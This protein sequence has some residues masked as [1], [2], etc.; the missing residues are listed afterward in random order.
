MDGD[1]ETQKLVR[2]LP[3]TIRVKDGPVAFSHIHQVVGRAKNILA[4]WIIMIFLFPAG[5]AAS[6]T[7]LFVR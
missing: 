7:P 2:V 5:R 6:H 1:R 3:K 4:F